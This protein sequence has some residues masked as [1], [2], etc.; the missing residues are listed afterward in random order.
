MEQN[1]QLHQT[2]GPAEQETREENTESSV[3]TETTDAENTGEPRKN[4]PD[5]NPAGVVA[6]SEEN[7]KVPEPEL[8]EPPLP[9]DAIADPSEEKPE[10]DAPGGN[11]RSVADQSLEI[12]EKIQQAETEAELESEEDED[13]EQD[14]DLDYSSLSQKE[15]LEKL[16][17]AVHAD[18]ISK[19]KSKVSLIKVEF[20]KK[21]REV[22]EI[23]LQQFIENGG[24]PETFKAPPDKDEERFHAV[25]E[26]YKSK[27]AL[28]NEQLE[29]QKIENLGAKVEILEKLKELVLSEEALKKTYDEFR[30]LQDRWKEIGQV[31]RNEV[32][33][34]WQNYHFLVEKFFDK[35]KINKELKDLDLKK[36]LEQKIILC[37][38][39]EELLLSTSIHKSFKLLQKYHEEWRELGPVPQD[40]KDEIWERF[41]SVS[42][43]I[44]QN[45]KEYYAQLQEDQEENL[46]AKSAL[47]DKLEALNNEEITSLPVWKEKTAE[48]EEMVNLWQSIG[49]APVKINDDIWQRFK[50]GLNQFY[51]TKKE[52]FNTLKDQQVTNYNLKLNLCLQA[53]ALAT[54]T[55]WRNTQNDFLRLQE[56]W[57]NIGPVPRKHSDK[58][59]KRFRSACDAFFKAKSHYFANINQMEQENLNK[60]IDLIR[61]IDEYEVQDDKKSNLEALRNFQREWVET[62][63]V[64]IGQ[65]DKIQN[66]Y[67]TAISNLLDKLKISSVEANTMDYKNRVES[68]KASPDGDRTIYRE[69]S[70]LEGKVSKL[71]ADINLWE[72]NIG[73]L[74]S[75]KN[76]DILKEEF[77]KKIRNA[78][79]ELALMKAKIKLLARS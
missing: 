76:A 74:A 12:T 55:N 40:K 1:D 34:L 9:E 73:F 26:V 60:K 49:R 47:C 63:H 24:T 44:N 7:L 45:R 54:S 21:L 18:D 59:W 36:N 67:R 39:A 69:R 11:D 23:Q 68:M 61:Q 64:P 79:E 75:S 17:T 4:D 27:K 35:V 57:R 10:E 3:T 38:K 16:E 51:N 5:E 53:E 52:F 71:Q 56:E 28:Y 48:V 66:T 62:G 6:A 46:L 30:E 32:N 78:K 33:N 72:N 37:E 29:K 15:L 65:K 77:E 19:A 43:R 14:A 70:F 50:K 22:K 8:E 13:D 25:F 58:I 20:L 31:P 42:D 2:S 41:K